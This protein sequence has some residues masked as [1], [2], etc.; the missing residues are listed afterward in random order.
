MKFIIT[1]DT[2]ADDQWSGNG[3]I[4]VAN[5]RHLSRFQSLCEEYGFSPSYLA[6]WEVLEDRESRE[7][8]RKWQKKG[9]A[10]IGAHLH[11]WTTPPFTEEEQK[12]PRVRSLPCELDDEALDQ[13]LTHLTER[14]TEEFHQPPEGFRAGR[15]GLDGR[16][17]SHLVRLGYLADCSVTPKLSWKET[18]GRQAGTGGPD[19]RLA[20]VRP[21]TMSHEDVCRPGAGGLL[22]VPATILYTGLLVRE[23]SAAAR[24]FSVLPEGPMKRMLDRLVFRR[25]WLRIEPWSRRRDWADIYRAAERNDLDVLEFMIHS[26]ELMPGGSPLSTAPQ[27]V[28]WIYG[29]I[30]D[31]FRDYSARGVEG[32]PLG[33]YARSHSALHGR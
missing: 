21:Y 13:K 23:E 5:I 6:A 28:E 27:S 20:P 15:W 7:T 16:L 33:E 4:S 22:E 11:P 14:L 31:L 29:L 30:T 24:W 17:V 1:V 19:F 18:I 26:S 3:R 8:L 12:D 9:T 10:E 25:R 2:E 32:I